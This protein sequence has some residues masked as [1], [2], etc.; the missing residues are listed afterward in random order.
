[1][2]P[3][4]AYLMAAVLSSVHT[5]N[6][7]E[8]LAGVF[9]GTADTSPPEQLVQRLLSVATALGDKKSLPA[10]LHRVATPREGRFDRWQWAALVGVLDALA[11]QGRSLAQLNKEQMTEQIKQML[12]EARRMEAD[13]RDAESERLAVVQVLGR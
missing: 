4:D 11:R 12:A 3:E 5:Q 9:A 13:T 7:P 8:V 10:I 1:K 6:L 2:H